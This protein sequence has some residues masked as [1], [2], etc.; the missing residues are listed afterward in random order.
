MFSDFSDKEFAKLLVISEELYSLDCKELVTRLEKK[1]I[2][3][4]IVSKMV[5]IQREEYN[6][7]I[8]N[9]SSYRDIKLD[10]VISGREYH[11]KSEN[12]KLV[13]SSMVAELPYIQNMKGF[14]DENII[15]ICKITRKG[16]KFLSFKIGFKYDTKI[17]LNTLKE[18]NK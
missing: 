4:D 14:S 7:N 10:N 15:S 2:P 6:L 3:Y 17:Y 5:N 12:L 9:H 11:F 16:E 13:L 18:V 8:V 1:E